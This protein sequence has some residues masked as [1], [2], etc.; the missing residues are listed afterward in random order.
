MLRHWEQTSRS[1]PLGRR[2]QLLSPLISNDWLKSSRLLLWREA[3]FNLQL[4][5]LLQSLLFWMP[6]DFELYMD[7]AFSVTKEDH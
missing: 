1:Y 4:H 3:V 5:K 7:K 6:Y 2:R